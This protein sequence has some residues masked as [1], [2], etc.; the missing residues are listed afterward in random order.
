MPLPRL[1]RRGSGATV[2]I[3]GLDRLIT[4]ETRACT[5]AY[6]QPGGSWSAFAA[7]VWAKIEHVG[8]KEVVNE[9]EYAAEISDRFT[10]PYV[11]GVSP[12][13]RVNYVDIDGKT[14]YFDILFVQNVE[15]RGLLMV[16]LAKEIYSNT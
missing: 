2:A 7:N 3:G 10:I 16:L 9:I 15:Q 4:I 6:N 8:G 1:S 14:R 11:A 12:K 13:M 5:N